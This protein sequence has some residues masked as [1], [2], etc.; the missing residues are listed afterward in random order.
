[1]QP[2]M[3]LTFHGVFFSFP[4]ISLLLQVLGQTDNCPTEHHYLALGKCYL[5]VDNKLSWT[6]AK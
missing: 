1:I 2:K 6:E 4:L 3:T 5:L